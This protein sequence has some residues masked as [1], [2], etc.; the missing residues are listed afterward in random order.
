MTQVIFAPTKNNN[1]SFETVKLNQKNK[2]KS[3]P[4][5]VALQT[6]KKY[7]KKANCLVSNVPIQKQNM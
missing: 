6:L 1:T 7:P 3:T 4:C 5:T 2:K